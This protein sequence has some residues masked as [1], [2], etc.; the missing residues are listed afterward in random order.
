MT[1]K[2]P[3]TRDYF[4]EMYVAGMMADVGWSIYFPRRDIGFDFIATIQLKD[5]I[6]IRPVQVKGKYPTESKKDK[7]SYGYSG[8]LSQL[9]EA[10]IL[11]IPYFSLTQID[12]PVCTAYMP[13]SLIRENS[14]RPGSM[15]CL[16]AKLLNGIPEP[17]RD[18]EKYF[19]EAGLSLVQSKGF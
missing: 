10:M 9:H 13:R 11:A 8:K 15:R 2:A 18:Y 5:E 17:R 4:A 12:S 1:N 14:N 3:S 19:N 6:L 7:L 16:P